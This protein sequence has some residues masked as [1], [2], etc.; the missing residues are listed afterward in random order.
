MPIFEQSSGFSR[1]LDTLDQGVAIFDKHL[2]LVYMNPVMKG[3]AGGKD[4]LSCSRDMFDQHRLLDTSGKAVPMEKFPVMLAFSGKDTIEES[5]EYV[6]STGHHTWL[7]VTCRRILDNRGQLEHVFTT[8]RNA[9]KRK[10][11][12][13]KLNFLL[14]SAKILN[15]TTDFRSRLQEQSRLVVP[16]LADWCAIDILQDGEIERVAMIHRDPLVS[17]VVRESE[18]L[19]QPSPDSPADSRAII[20]SQKPLFIPLLTERMISVIGG[21]EHPSKQN[22]KSLMVIPIAVRGKGLGAMT[23]AYAESG[24]MYT[25]EDF[26]FFQEFCYHLGAIFESSHFLGEIERRDKA[27]DIFIATLSHELRNPLSPIKS[28]LELV[29]LQNPPESVRE[30]L[31]IIEHSVDHLAKLLNDLLDVTRF[32][33]GMI[34]IEPRLLDVRHTLSHAIKTMQPLVAE[35]GVE[36]K[37]VIPEEPVVVHADETRLEQAV[38]NLLSNAVKFTPRGGTIW[39]TLAAKEGEAQI[40]IRDTGIGIS[41]RDLRHVFDMFYQAERSKHVSGGLGIGLLLVDSIARLHKGSVQ[42]KSKGIGKGSEFTLKLPLAIV[43]SEVAQSVP[44]V[45]GVSA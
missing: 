26:G 41:G 44:S 21:S 15:I 16:E 7:S 25:Q 20:E 34:A 39:A 37:V 14:E 10:S 2:H 11:N 42:A 38:M 9:S 27:K 36:L 3:M 6:D 4:F 31:A 32:T 13:S 23:L 43:V 29:R 8:V 1:I 18:K 5:F 22:I 35:S 19:F 30:E 12:E 17:G 40:S 28:A 45:S 33:R 24:R